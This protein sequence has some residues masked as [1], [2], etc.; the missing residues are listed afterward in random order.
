MLEI[1]IK[2]EF[3]AEVVGFNNSG[4]PL[5]KRSQ[6]DLIDLALMAHKAPGFRRY[7]EKLPSIK[8]LTEAKG[9][10]FLESGNVV[11]L[12]PDT[13]VVVAPEKTDDSNDTQTSKGGR[14]AKS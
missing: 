3:K 12:T 2:E 9:Q 7:F 5:G 14:K 10:Q 13:P 1:K 4:L 6:A 8:Q 11:D